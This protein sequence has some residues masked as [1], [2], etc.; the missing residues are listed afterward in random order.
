M[1]ITCGIH[2]GEAH[3]DVARVDHEGRVLQRT[4]IRTPRVAKETKTRRS[5]PAIPMPTPDTNLAP[6]NCCAA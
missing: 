4:R 3:H 5:G 1:P 6:N 2:W